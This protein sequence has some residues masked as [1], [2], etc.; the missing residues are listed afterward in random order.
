MAKGVEDTTHY[1]YNRLLSL[2]EVGGRPGH[3]GCSLEEF[4]NFNRKKRD[5]WPDCL[6]A[7]STH[8]TRRGEDARAR[9]NA[10]SDAGR[11]EKKTPTWIRINRGK[12]KRI[13]GLAAPDRNDEYFLYQTLI[14]ALAIFEMP[15]IPTSFKESRRILSKLSGKPKSIPRG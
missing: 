9:I 13:Q 15:I 6:N 11:V 12:K 8:D 7:T 14:G 10:L 5:L 3:F 4:H 1:V 2:N